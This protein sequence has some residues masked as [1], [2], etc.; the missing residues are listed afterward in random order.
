MKF[1]N[2][3]ILGPEGRLILYTKRMYPTTGPMPIQILEIA[4]WDRVLQT[5]IAEIHHIKAVNKQNALEKTHL[6]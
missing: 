3:H 5:I 6:S 4:G 2:F 1:N